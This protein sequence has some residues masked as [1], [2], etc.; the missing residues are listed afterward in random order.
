MLSQHAAKNPNCPPDAKLK[1]LK[2]TNQIGQY[3]EEDFNLRDEFTTPEIQRTNLAA[4]I[5]QM[6]QQAL[7]ILEHVLILNLHIFTRTSRHIF[8]QVHMLTNF[9]H[10]LLSGKKI[11]LLGLL[12]IM[13]SFQ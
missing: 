10:I 12:M 9:I 2:E 3:S 13:K 7:L 1:W 5:L 4:V 8:L 11:Q 6:A